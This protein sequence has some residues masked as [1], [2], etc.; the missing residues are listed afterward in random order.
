MPDSWVSNNLISAGY[1]LDF[2]FLVGH[3]MFIRRVLHSE[4]K[5][6]QE[7][8][9]EAT[10]NLSKEQNDSFYERYGDGQYY[11]EDLFPSI[12]WSAM[13]VSA[14]NLFEKTMNDICRT[15][16]KHSESKVELKD[17]KGKGIHRAKLYLSKALNVKE[18]FTSDD[19]REIQN[20]SKLRNVLA[21]TSGELDLSNKTHLKVYE[22]SKTTNDIIIKTRSVFARNDELPEYADIVIMEQL[23]FDAIERYR[24]FI[25]V[26]LDA[27]YEKKH[28]R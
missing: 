22:M 28:I 16:R 4:K 10:K 6:L 18:P 25:S 11:I 12:Q 19:W 3:C 15:N 7:K 1:D 21:H 26:I 23:V 13:Y 5:E 14:Y 24:K 8:Y 9:T 17:L 27:V 2:D 20:C